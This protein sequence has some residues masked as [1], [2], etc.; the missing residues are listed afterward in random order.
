LRAPNRSG[1]EILVHA[2]LKFDVVLLEVLA[3][4]EELLV[5]AAERRA[6]IA[7][8]K[9]CGIEA[10]RAIPADLSHGQAHQRLYAGQEDLPGVLGIFLIEADR[11]LVDSHS[12]LAKA[13]G[14]LGSFSAVA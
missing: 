10:H 4:S 14:R 8:D 9:A 11:T 5:I 2:G 1:G 7:G 12:T 3:R 13:F 6:T